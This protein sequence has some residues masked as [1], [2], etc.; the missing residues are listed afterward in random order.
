MVVL[1]TSAG[2]GSLAVGVDGFGSF[3]P[4]LYPTLFFPIDPSRNSEAIYDPIGDLAATNTVKA[5]GLTIRFGDTGNRTILTE[6]R[7]AAV[8]NLDDPELT[9]TSAT[10]AV[11]TFN[12]QDLDFILNQSV[13][14]ILVGDERSGSTLIQ[15]YNITNTSDQVLE[16]EIIRYVD[17]SLTFDG[18]DI[19]TGGR[20]FVDGQE[21]LFETDAGNDPLFSTTFLGITA[22]GG[23]TEFST[24]F[25]IDQF[26][27]FDQFPPRV[28]PTDLVNGLPLDNE[29]RG[30]GSDEDEFVDSASYDVILALQHDFR[31]NPGESTTYITQTIFGAGIPQEVVLPPEIEFSQTTYQVEE[32]INEAIITLN[33]I[34]DINTNST[35]EIQ[36][37]DGTATGG[38]DFNDTTITVNFAVGETN[39]TV[40]VPINDDTVEEPDEDLILTLTNSSNGTIIGTQNSAILEIFDNDSSVTPTPTP[41]PLPVPEPEPLPDPQPTPEPSPIPTPVTPAPEVVPTPTPLPTPT[42]DPSPVPT[43]QP[44]TPAPEVVPTP[45]PLPTPQPE[46]LP[47]PDPS[48]VPT[49]Q[50][51]TP[52]PEVV[53]TP[54]PLP[55]PQPEP[56]PTPD[57]SPVPTPQPVTPAPEVVPTPE[58]L[59]TPQ[60]EPLP[61]PDPSPV[62]T[63]QPV[64]PAPEVVPTPEPNPIPIP[65][66]QPTPEATPEPNP[67][68]IPQPQPVT[69][70]PEVVPEIVPEAEPTPI[71]PV[72]EVVPP[73]ELDITSPFDS[74]NLSPIA[75]D[76]FIEIISNFGQAIKVPDLNALSFTSDIVGYK[77]TELPNP[78]TGILLILFDEIT[79]LGQV[80]DLTLEQASE[81]FFLPTP[82]FEGE[83]SFDYVARDRNGGVSEE[84]TVTLEIEAYTDSITRDQSE[85]EINCDCLPLTELSNI[86]VIED[87]NAEASETTS[88]N[89]NFIAGNNENNELFG[90][91]GNDTI[92]G[93]NT[94]IESGSD[95][96]FGN[97]GEDLLIGYGGN[98]FIYSGESNDWSD[99]G[100][101]ND[102]IWG[103]QGSDTLRG[104]Q[105]ND[106][107]IGDNI[108]LESTSTQ[109]DRL[110]GG[111]GED[112]IIGNYDN[113]TLEGNEGNDTLHGGQNDDQVHGG[114]GNDLI[115][116]DLGD[117]Y[118]CGNTGDDTLFG[119]QL[120]PES[121]EADFGAD[122]LC[123]G[124][125]N[126]L[127]FGNMNNDLLCGN[128]GN[129]TLYGGLG[130]DT[131]VSNSGE[132]I[133]FGDAGNDLISGGENRDQFVLFVNS[134]TDT[135]TN[136]Q[137]ELDIIILG[138]SLTFEQLTLEQDETSAL[139]KF[140]TET[141]AILNDVDITT[142]TVDNFA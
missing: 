69:P 135:I 10:N 21:I 20:L 34:G 104:E 15:T 31:L 33:R 55:T 78:D 24:A 50:P 103:D 82:G 27:S 44:V 49:P 67:I 83:T 61:T 108:E 90:N 112:I 119:D 117:D 124:V 3:G 19:N 134:G 81:L 38:T 72:D 63:P 68:P 45:E 46:P 8:N 26:T 97:T 57:P 29:V 126:D 60:P 105:G 116:G 65:Q 64:T 28:F 111:L 12:F 39:Q 101:G 122:T 51:V 120:I 132:N 139:I 7:I 87:L 16:F 53:P 127:L 75:E 37:I 74:L 123:G 138:D 86:P 56:L 73:F 133:F 99:G 131:L 1:S 137:I 76:F 118:L 35:V 70:A 115:F 121:T 9:Q 85:D 17:G 79:N 58:P 43:P 84:A 32:D 110:V 4:E 130:N 40:T 11:S 52:A 142:L 96:L 66:P 2:D 129:D 80:E 128:E 94:A 25:D 13:Q 62:P 42:P 140:G 6:G 125:G 107:L 71:T 109:A 36:L 22:S 88:E 23:L 136:F 100:E 18:S 54:E 47:T 30:D 102:K 48:P 98:D 77:I 141:L 93:D 106:T 95:T 113:D 92:I 5:S 59:P 41:E 14:D 114:E 91:G 89:S